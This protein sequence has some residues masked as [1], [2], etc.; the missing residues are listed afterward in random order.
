MFAEGVAVD[1]DRSKTGN[2]HDDSEN[3]RLVL[4]GAENRQWFQLEMMRFPAYF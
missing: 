3:N 4:L 1:L 2:V